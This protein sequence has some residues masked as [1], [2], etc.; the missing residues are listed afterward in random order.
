MRFLDTDNQGPVRRVHLYLSAREAEDLRAALERLLLDPEA[1]EHAHVAA[2]DGSRELSV[3][4]VTPG[5]LRDAQR[6]TDAERR[7]FAEP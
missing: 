4:L 5:K 1:Y 7:M 6:Y 3:S 2:E